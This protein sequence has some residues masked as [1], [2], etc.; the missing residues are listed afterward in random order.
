ML[1]LLAALLL[2]F[3]VKQRPPALSYSLSSFLKN[4][5]GEPRIKK[6][7]FFI[8]RMAAV[9]LLVIALARPR[10]GLKERS[11][12]KASVDI[13]LV[14]DVSTS[15]RALD[16]KPFNRMEAAVNAAREFIKARTSDRM[17]VVVFSGLPVLQCP[18]TLDNNAVLRLMDKVDAGMIKVDGTAIGLGISLGLKYLEKSD[19]P[20]RLMV[21][22]TDGANNTGDIDPLTAADM[23]KSLG[24]KIYTIGSGKP[25][26]AQVPVK[27]P[28]FGTRLVT[29]P[30]ELD[31]ATLTKIASKTG[32]RYFRATS[33]KKLK[34]IYSEIDRMEKKQIAVIEFYEFEEK[35]HLFLF[36]GSFLLLLEIILRFL[37]PGIF[38]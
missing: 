37:M 7:L 29:I 32:G 34:E 16:F 4:R 25:G 8:M 23:A 22:L 3:K 12:V 10:K 33:L 19:S 31:E 30:D 36:L 2:Y 14:M 21:L 24:V 5:V 9:V 27:H 20:S 38:L 28:Y 1:I 18:L 35:F 6:N 15:M 11:V 17:G 26:P 13:I